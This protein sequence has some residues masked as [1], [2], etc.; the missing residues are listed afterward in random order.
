MFNKSEGNTHFVKYNSLF[1]D[2]LLLKKIL[3]NETYG[4]IKIFIDYLEN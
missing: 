1:Q 3:S 4:L 2:V